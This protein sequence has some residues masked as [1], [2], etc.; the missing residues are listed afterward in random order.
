MKGIIAAAL[1]ALATPAFA[2]DET[3]MP[4]LAPDGEMP[5]TSSTDAF[6]SCIAAVTPLT[7]QLGAQLGPSHVTT[8]AQW[9]LVW[10]ADFHIAGTD[11]QSVNRIVCWKGRVA[12]A[13]GQ[14][15]APLDVS[16]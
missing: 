16:L 2:A 9:G 1:L 12:I 13:L 7:Q 15:L 5:V 14:H 11:P 4:P 6:A 8:S 10:R 3:P